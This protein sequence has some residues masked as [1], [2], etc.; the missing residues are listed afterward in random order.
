MS[1]KTPEEAVRRF[2]TAWEA[3]DWNSY[4]ASVVVNG[5]QPS[6]KNEDAARRVFDGMKISF[7]NLS[8]KTATDGDEKATVFLTGGTITT[9]ANI[10]GK[11]KT[12]SIDLAKV[13][14]SQRPQFRVVKV[15]DTWFV[16]VGTAPSI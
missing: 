15:G 3:G 1:G 7:N 4:K 5:V 14:D 6:G 16:E 2:L 12:S 9:T 10:L 13:A 11:S 8:M